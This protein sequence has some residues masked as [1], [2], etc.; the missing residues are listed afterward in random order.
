MYVIRITIIINI[1]KY[2]KLN[3]M[4]TQEEMNKG[5]D[6]LSTFL[7]EQMEKLNMGMVGDLITQEIKKELKGIILN[8]N[9]DVEPF[10]GGDACIWVMNHKCTILNYDAVINGCIK[11]VV[12]KYDSNPCESIISESGYFEGYAY[13]GN[14]EPVFAKTLL[15]EL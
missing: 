7:G 10:A 2:L 4:K 11:F 5:L 12:E 15:I 1:V 14:D 9:F 3:T 6:N 8:E 13:V